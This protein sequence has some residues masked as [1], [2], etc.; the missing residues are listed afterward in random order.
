MSTR[1]LA[2][3]VAFSEDAATSKQ[4]SARCC[5]DDDVVP[6]AERKTVTMRVRKLGSAIGA[7]TT[8]FVKLL[9]RPVGGTTVVLVPRERVPGAART[10][11]VAEDLPRAS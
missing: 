1:G 6:S 2:L 5:T 11:I 10:V 8:V 9:R 3:Y 7:A 4:R